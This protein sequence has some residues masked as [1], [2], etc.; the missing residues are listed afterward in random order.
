MTDFDPLLCPAQFAKW[1]ET[2]T[3]EERD[4]HARIWSG[5]AIAAMTLLE[6]VIKMKAA[7]NKCDDE[8]GYEVRV[9]ELIDEANDIA[10]GLHDYDPTSD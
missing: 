1:L 3:P 5:R 6:A 9:E 10:R 4:K 8:T 7:F 2:A